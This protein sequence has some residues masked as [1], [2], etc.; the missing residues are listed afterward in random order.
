MEIDIMETVN[1]GVFGNTVL[2]NG[3]NVSGNL[4]ED[5]QYLVAYIVEGLPLPV[6]GTYTHFEGVGL[7]Y[8]MGYFGIDMKLKDWDLAFPIRFYIMS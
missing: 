1:E 7:R 5:K 3:F 6:M 4:T 8:K 2:I